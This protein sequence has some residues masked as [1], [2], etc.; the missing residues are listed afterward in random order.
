MKC[1]AF[2]M[3]NNTKRNV[4]EFRLRQFRV[5]L[6]RLS[7]SWLF[8]NRVLLKPALCVWGGG[9]EEVRMQPRKLSVAYYEE[10]QWNQVSG[11]RDFDLSALLA[12]RR[13]KWQYN[14][15]KKKK[16]KKKQKKTKKQKKK[17]NNKQQKTW[18]IRPTCSLEMTQ[19]TSEW[20]S[21]RSM[22]KRK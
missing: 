5:V 16:T 6:F 18:M 11:F 2:L 9:G 7:P 12:V 8:K 4:L 15:K 10:T 13:R 21:L 22:W 17:N 3:Q 14:K 20:A 1:K 19:E